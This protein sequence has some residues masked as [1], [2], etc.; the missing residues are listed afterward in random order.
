MGA[1]P[2]ARQQSAIPNKPDGSCEAGARS[3][4]Q[5]HY[6]SVVLFLC[7]VTL[8]VMVLLLHHYP[9]SQLA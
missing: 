1:P 8:I 3:N 5:Q 4:G 7:Y 9:S 2:C 6:D